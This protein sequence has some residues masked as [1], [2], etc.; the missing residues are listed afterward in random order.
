MNYYRNFNKVVVHFL[1]E[2]Y[3]VVALQLQGLSLRSDVI[4]NV[5]IEVEDCAYCLI[6]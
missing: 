5:Y 1:W 6:L 4:D 3:L 2:C